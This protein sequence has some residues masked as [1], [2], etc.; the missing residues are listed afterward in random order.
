MRLHLVDVRAD[1]VAAWRDAFSEFPE[2]A[3]RLGD[4]LSLASNTIVS[5]ANSH[6]FMDGGIDQQ[7]VSFFGP[8]LQRRVHEAVRA[9][10]EGLLP[11]G[12]SA[13][14]ETGH[15]RVPF[16]V[17]A[18]T[19]EMPEAVPAA[20]AYRALR[21]TL[22]LVGADPAVG[23]DVFCPGLGTLTG[24]IPP[25]DAAVEMASAYR[26]WKLQAAERGPPVEGARL[27]LASSGG[28]DGT[29]GV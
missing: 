11:V 23:R 27:R 26:D 20:H 22:R 6:G 8:A 16:L 4:I 3:I 24:R 7:Y 29:E 18:P 17:L 28:G 25:A 2:V 13:L 10:P 21:A 15:P 5:P 14:V 12:A 9:R 19:M 1:L